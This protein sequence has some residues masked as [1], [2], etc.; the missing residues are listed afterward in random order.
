MK[1]VLYITANTVKQIL[2]DEP[3]TRSSDSLLYLKVIERI[4]EEQD[5]DLEKWSVPYFL[6]NL[7]HT[8]FP[9]FES[10]RRARQKIQAQHPELSANA[11]VQAQREINEAEYR[12]FARG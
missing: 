2:T 7:S 5:I 12:E 8:F 10:V 9:P 11:K 1:N 6:R 4:A 3:S